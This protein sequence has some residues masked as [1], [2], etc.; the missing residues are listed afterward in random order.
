M[1][2]ESTGEQHGHPV[3]LS[4]E[5]EVNRKKTKKR[6]RTHRIRTMDYRFRMNQIRSERRRSLRRKRDYRDLRSIVEQEGILAAQIERQRHRIKLLSGDLKEM[7]RKAVIGD[8][9]L[10]KRASTAAEKHAVYLGHT[11]SEERKQLRRLEAKIKQKI[12]IL[13]KLIEKQKM[14]KFM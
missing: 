12:T 13:N 8:Q 11:V 1:N 6:K 10:G 2:S 5:G 7:T 14:L 9:E 4:S 3:V